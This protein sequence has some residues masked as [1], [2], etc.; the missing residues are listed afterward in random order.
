MNDFL[1]KIE[2]RK[3]T[4]TEQSEIASKEIR[5]IIVA[6]LITAFGLAFKDSGFNFSSW[7]LKIAVILFVFYFGLDMAQY[8]LGVWKETPKGSKYKAS[9]LFFFYIKFLP[10]FTGLGFILI[11]II[12]N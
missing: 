5:K 11:D 7:N 2:Y 1:S 4:I 12:S 8:I 3:N 6:L 10:A 9:P